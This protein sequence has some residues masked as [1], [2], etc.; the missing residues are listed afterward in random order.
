[1]YRFLLTNIGDDDAAARSSREERLRGQGL[2]LRATAGHRR[3]YASDATPVHTLREGIFVVGHLFSRRDFQRKDA[4]SGFRCPHGDPIR[5]VLSHWWGEYVLLDLRDPGQ[6]SVLRDPSGGMGCIH[7][8]SG[9]FVASDVSVA[10]DAGLYS[11]IV[12]WDVI[13]T[14]M[15]YPHFKVGRTALSGI[16]ELLPGAELVMKP[17]NLSTVGRWSPWQ[18]I[19]PASRHTDLDAAA[20]HV[21]TTV[22]A[23]VKALADADGDVLLELSGGLDSSIVAAAL[24]RSRARVHCCNLVT[25]VPGAD[26]RAYAQPMA[27]LLDVRLHTA[28]LG[29]HDDVFDFPPPPAAAL[30]STWFLQHASNTLKEAFG[31]ALGVRSFFSGGGGDTVFCYSHNA[32]PA[33]DAWRMAGVGAG[34]RAVL[35]LAELHQCTV[36]TAARL[37]LRKRF[38]PSKPARRPDRTFLA[39][40]CHD[41]A[42]PVHPW[43][44]APPGALPG[45][46]ERVHDLVGT[47]SFRDGFA[48]SSRWH[49][50]MPLLA[51]PVVEACLRVPSWMWIREG[52]NRSVARSAYSDVLPPS[53]LHRRSKGTFVNYAGTV[54]ARNRL[55]I[56]DFLSEGELAARGLLDVDAVRGYFAHPTV[57]RENDFMRIFELCS[58]ENWVR[59]QH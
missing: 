13:T 16:S 37:A 50:R 11:R 15:V 25:P 38:A 1:M 6:L 28:T 26:E 18:H 19:A 20:R 42:M 46:R 44:V 12:D 57:E 29:F 45:D 34:L 14:R 51:Q 59:H 47:Q 36:W 58:V 23:V 49:F 35:D 41:V 17:G 27:D 21:R 4:G 31:E 10:V 30:P 40:N 3:L 9:A 2:D 54:F 55:R 43:F 7:A 33:A 5:H 22:D 56:R 48:R 39:S 53:V 52:R 24:R 8:D 32:S